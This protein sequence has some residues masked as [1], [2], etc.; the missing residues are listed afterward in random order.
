MKS[1][2]EY[3]KTLESA[4]RLLKYRDRSK[5]ELRR[6]LLRKG[7]PEETVSEVIEYLCGLDFLNDRRF[8]QSWVNSRTGSRARGRSSLSSEL[9]ARGVSREVILDVLRGHDD[10]EEYSAAVCVAKEKLR[11]MDN[12]CAEK[13]KQ[14]LYGHLRRRGFASDVIVRILREKI[15]DK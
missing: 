5:V 13:K 14:R 4:F 7:Y 15:D 8:A 2:D 6:R 10:S 12:L 1:A 3:R 9:Q 11:R